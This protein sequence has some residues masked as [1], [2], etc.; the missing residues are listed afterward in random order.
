[1]RGFKAEVELQISGNVVRQ[2]PFATWLPTL[3]S[4]FIQSVVRSR[5]FLSCYPFLVRRKLESSGVMAHTK[6]LIF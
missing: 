6:V 2:Y 1:M 4:S 3:P 5:C